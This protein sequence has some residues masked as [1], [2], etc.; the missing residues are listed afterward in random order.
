MV[1]NIC[2][3]VRVC[4][5]RGKVVGWWLDAGGREVGD[6]TALNCGKGKPLSRYLHR[7]MEGQERTPAASYLGGT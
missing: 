1:I 5:R 6:I 4:V 7:G 3:Y 2:A